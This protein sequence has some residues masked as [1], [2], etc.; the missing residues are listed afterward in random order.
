M[1]NKIKNIALTIINNDFKRIIIELILFVVLFNLNQYVGLVFFL[2]VLFETIICK[3]NTNLLYIYIFLSFFDEILIFDLLQGSISRIIMIVVSIKLGL[4]TIKNRIFPNKIQFSLALFFLISCLIEFFIIGFNFSTIIVLINIYIFILFSMC[5]KFKKANEM[6]DFIERLCLTIV[7]AVLFSIIYGICTNN[8]LV[9]IIDYEKNSK[10]FRFNGTYEPNFMCMYINLGILS[11]LTVKEKFNKIWYFAIFAIM[12]NF[13]ILTAS[14]TGLITLAFSIFIYLVYNFKNK[15][16]NYKNLLII[17]I[18]SL[19]LFF[20]INVITNQFNNNKS[21]SEKIEI[22]ESIKEKEDD[23]NEEQKEDKESIKEENNVVE[24]NEDAKIEKGSPII[25]RINRI[26]N[27]ILE[28]K[29]DDITSGRLPLLRTFIK[30][31]FDRPIFNILFGNGVTTKKIFCT[32]FN[33]ECLSH[34]TYADFLYNFGVIGFVLIIW[35]L[36]YK[37]RKN[38]FSNFNLKNSKYETNIKIIRIMLLLYSLSLTLYT[39]RMFL[40]FFLL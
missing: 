3:K 34:N 24:E 10:I 36:S 22:T 39:K 37:T 11:L 4:F 21:Q 7:F 30:A 13:A 25:Q 12:I 20:I 6:N 14:M 9:Q 1:K 8:F 31:S 35:F 18:A 19:V 29:L 40:I 33:R 15:K 38:V 5:I 2:L 16:I 28:G 17:S 27:L 23:L 26:K 32:F